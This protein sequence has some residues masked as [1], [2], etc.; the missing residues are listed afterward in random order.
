MAFS[1]TTQNPPSANGGAPAADRGPSNA[2]G[3]LPPSFKLHR[4]LAVGPRV[5]TELAL[6]EPT[7]TDIQ[8][9]AKNPP[10]DDY[11]AAIRG[12]AMI[13]G[14]SPQA[15]DNLHARDFLALTAITADRFREFE[16]A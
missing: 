10:T 11:D 2:A 12:I 4:P 15:L 6:R 1:P 16:G 8:L 13:T 5:F 9:W 7:L 14:L 3:A